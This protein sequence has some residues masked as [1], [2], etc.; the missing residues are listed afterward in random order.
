MEIIVFLCL[1]VVVWIFL[2]IKAVIEISKVSYK[3]RMKKVIWTNLVVIFPFLGL[4]AY[5]VYGKQSL[6]N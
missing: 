6:Q 2:S 1:I 3:M 4:I 5:Y